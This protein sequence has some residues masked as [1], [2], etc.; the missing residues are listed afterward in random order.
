MVLNQLHRSVAVKYSNG[1]FRYNR[2][3]FHQVGANLVFAR[4]ECC[5]GRIQ[6]SP[7]R[8]FKTYVILKSG[9][10]FDIVMDFLHDNV[11]VVKKPKQTFTIPLF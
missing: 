4:K 1:V 6:D 10:D 3:D 11:V 5:T 8:H 7:L 9:N 2:G